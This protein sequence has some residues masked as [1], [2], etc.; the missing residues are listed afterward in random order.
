MKKKGTIE[1]I[2]PTVATIS[3]IMVWGIAVWA[4]VAI[5]KNVT[6]KPE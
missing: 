6:R 5:Y 1:K 3:D 4:C 2:G